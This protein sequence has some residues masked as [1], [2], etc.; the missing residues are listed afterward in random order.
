LVIYYSH[1]NISIVDYIG[2]QEYITSFID[3]IIRYLSIFGLGVI[4]YLILDK[5]NKSFKEKSEL[6]KEELRNIA[7]TNANII[8]KLIANNIE[9]QIAD[10]DVEIKDIENKSKKINPDDF[11]W[12]YLK[13][14]KQKK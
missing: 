13:R 11:E 1:F 8:E 7:K 6:Q 4:V 3:D 14:L 2:L 12:G 10:L 5:K 9:K